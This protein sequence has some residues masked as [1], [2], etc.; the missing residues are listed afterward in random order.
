VNRT[1]EEFGTLT[2]SDGT[3]IPYRQI[4]PTD[5][6]AL[7][8]FHG[9]HS[10]RTLH[11]RFFCYQPEL[12]E[13]QARYFTE[14]DGIDR[15]ALVALD[16]L[17]EREIIAV[18]RFDREPGTTTAEYAAVVADAWQGYGLGTQLTARLIE[19]A[20]AR[21]VA[22]I[23]AYVLPENAMMLSL[24]RDLRLPTKI[25]EESGVERIEVTLPVWTKS[26]ADALKRAGTAPALKS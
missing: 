1:V 20:R 5:R 8:R 23:V 10:D 21:G 12:G 14:L 2:I 19:C 17:D 6:E 4:A 11:L 26:T 7:R 24:L 18:A 13:S 22:T 3:A 25:R 16:P 15:F 9:R